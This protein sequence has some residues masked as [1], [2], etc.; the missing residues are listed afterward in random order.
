[1]KGN[2]QH[3]GDGRRQ[4]NEIYRVSGV[5]RYILRL[6]S[7]DFSFFAQPLSRNSQEIGEAT[8]LTLKPVE[9]FARSVENFC[10]IGG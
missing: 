2:G 9:N 8:C 7:S 10:G 6:K 3:K 4:F 5:S 1:M